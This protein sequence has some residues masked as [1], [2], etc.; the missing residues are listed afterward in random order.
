MS[1]K[2]CSVETARLTRRDLLW[3]MGGG[4]A[5][6]GLAQMLA[7]G[8]AQ[9]AERK[10]GPHFASKAKNVILIFLPGGIS[11][12]DTFDCKPDLE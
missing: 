10:P 11:S 3:R 4:A 5:G 8:S 2:N 7:A 9:A 6:I 12:V 1:H